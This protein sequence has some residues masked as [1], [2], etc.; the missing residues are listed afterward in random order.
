VQPESEQRND[1]VDETQRAGGSGGEGSEALNNKTTSH[2]H[3]P[4]WHSSTLLADERSGHDRQF[5]YPQG[6]AA[7]D[8]ALIDDY[9]KG[10]K[11]LPPPARGAWIHTTS[12]ALPPIIDD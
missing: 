3:R 2:H 12:S 6:F 1:E 8:V 9:S 4:K 11:A 7:Q 10:A 5:R